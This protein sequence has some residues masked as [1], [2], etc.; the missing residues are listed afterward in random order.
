MTITPTMFPLYSGK[1]FDFNASP[2]EMAK[3]IDIVDIAH[4]LSQKCRFGGQSPVFY[5]VAQHSVL[6]S[7]VARTLTTDNQRSWEL[8]LEGLLHDAAEA[9]MGDVVSP[10]KCLMPEYKKLEQK[11]EGVVLGHF[12]IKRLSEEIHFADRVLLRTEQ[13]DIMGRDDEEWTYTEGVSP[14]TWRIQAMSM[15]D[16][17]ID[18]YLEYQR[19]LDK[20]GGAA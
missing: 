7:K 18:F 5:S 1:W 13:R 11:I 9:Y 4:A 20:L 10:L 6:V 14:M 15:K 16:A 12:G 8:A 2:S 17:E 19:I 3:S